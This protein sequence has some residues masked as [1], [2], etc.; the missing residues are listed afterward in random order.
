[1]AGRK[2]TA[3]IEKIMREAPTSATRFVRELCG[4]EI[5]YNRGTYRDIYVFEPDPR[6]VVKVERKEEEPEFANVGE[7]RNYEWC[8]EWKEFGPWLAPCPHSTPY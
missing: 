2:E 6:Y 8:R 3:R 4:E 7:W 5:G 1:M